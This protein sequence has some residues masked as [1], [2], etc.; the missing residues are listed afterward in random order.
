MPER[1][2]ASRILRW[3]LEETRVAEM[4]LQKVKVSVGEMLDLTCEPHT[5]AFGGLSKGARAEGLEVR[6]T[7][8]E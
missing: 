4:P 5:M 7:G 3:A 1:V 6:V 8:I 2:Y